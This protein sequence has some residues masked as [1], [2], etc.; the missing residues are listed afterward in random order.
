MLQQI[1]ES[2]THRFASHVW[3]RIFEIKWKTPFPVLYER[4]CHSLKGHWAIIAND[5]HGSLVV[6]C[7]FENGGM[8]EKSQIIDEIFVNLQSVSKGMYFLMIYNFSKTY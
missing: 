6:Q 5:E 7:I 2:I 1:N 8:H 4:V 3:Q